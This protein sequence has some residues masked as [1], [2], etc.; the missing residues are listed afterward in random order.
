MKILLCGERSFASIGLLNKLEVAGFDVDCFSRGEENKVDKSITGNVFTMSQNNYFAEYYDIIINFILIK[1]KTI[2]ENIAFIKELDRFCELKKVSRLIQISSISVYS[3]EAAFV[4]ENT[5]IE[6]DYE[7][8]G[9]Y[10]SV[11]IA[12]D[13]FLLQKKTVYPV[14]FIRPGYIVC[15]KNNFSYAGIGISLPMNFILLLGNEKTSLPL[16]NRDKMHN[17]LVNLLLKNQYK[18]VYLLLENNKGTKSQFLKSRSKGRIIP[19]PKSIILFCAYMA[20]KLSII[21]EKQLHQIKGLFKKTY[22]DSSETEKELQIK[23]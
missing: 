2:E 4:N 1:N 21:S 22:F 20:R 11:K 19:L 18:T 14:T 17:A 8:K 6:Q 23:F 12:V 15:E 13:Q 10:A 16:I 9:I 3:N 7:T 5:E